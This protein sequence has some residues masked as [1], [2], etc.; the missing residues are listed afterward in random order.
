MQQKRE[1]RK[2]IKE[3]Y[4]LNV[5][6]CVF[7]SHDEIDKDFLRRA[8]T[9]IGKMEFLCGVCVGDVH[10]IYEGRKIKVEKPLCFDHLQ[11]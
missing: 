1:E 7:N 5:L 10:S 11:L 4:K 6:I 2:K 9:S 3:R 8:A